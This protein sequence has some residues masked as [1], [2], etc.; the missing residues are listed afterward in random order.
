MDLRAYKRLATPIAIV[1]MGISGRAVLKLLREQGLEKS[2]V[3]FDTTPSLSDFQG[4]I[5]MLEVAKPRT[6]V[7][8]PGVPLT[9]PWIMN[10]VKK[11]GAVTSELTLATHGLVGE[12]IIAITGSLGEKYSSPSFRGGSGCLFQKLFRGR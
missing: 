1:G 7:V 2:L 5:E 11:G 6:L 10:F 4:P 8:S 12:K 3:R 9:S